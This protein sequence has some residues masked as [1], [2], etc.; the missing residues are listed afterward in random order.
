MSPY[1]SSF[2]SARG[3]PGTVADGADLVSHVPLRTGILQ[4]WLQGSSPPLHKHPDLGSSPELEAP[5]ARYASQ[6][7]QPL[8]DGAGPAPQHVLCFSE[9]HPSMI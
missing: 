9:R 7:L 6:S 8:V 4:V 5:N 2:L 1:E 3:V